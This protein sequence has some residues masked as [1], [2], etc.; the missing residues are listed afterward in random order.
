MNDFTRATAVDKRPLHTQF[1][2]H[3]PDFSRWFDEMMAWGENGRCFW[4]VCWQDGELIANGQLLIYPHGAEYANI[5]VAP[6]WQ[7]QGIGTAIIAAF[8]DIARKNGLREVEIGVE[9]E[10]GRA[11]ALY[12]RLGFVEDRRVRLMGGKTAVILHKT[13]TANDK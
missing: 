6:A 8:D 7:G 2:S 4:L 12:Q 1:Y 13:V 10:N 9:L 3:K 11:L 5:A